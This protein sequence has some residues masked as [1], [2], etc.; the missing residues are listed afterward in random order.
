MRE[1]EA[2]P[3]EGRDVARTDEEKSHMPCQEVLSFFFFSEGLESL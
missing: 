2:M 3:H 1:V